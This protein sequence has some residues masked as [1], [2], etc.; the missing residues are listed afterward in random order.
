VKHGLGLGHVCQEG[1]VK[2]GGMAGEQ[3]QREVLMGPRLGLFV[4]IYLKSTLL[5]RRKGR[6]LFRITPD[7]L[8]GEIKQLL[9]GSSQ[10]EIFSRWENGQWRAQYRKYS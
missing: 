8:K 5:M 3:E 7:P 6:V 4:T 2:G 10:K 9:K 1:V